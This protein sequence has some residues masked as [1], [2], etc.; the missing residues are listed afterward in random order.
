MYAPITPTPSGLYSCGHS[1][2]GQA[3]EI[4]VMRGLLWYR[5]KTT[6]EE[7]GPDIKAWVFPWNA[8]LQMSS[9]FHWDDLGRL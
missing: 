1:G 5:H 4:V 7:A 3:E 6:W 9:G 8:I 2:C